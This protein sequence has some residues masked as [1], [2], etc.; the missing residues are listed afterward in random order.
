MKYD[1]FFKRDSR[2]VWVGRYNKN[3]ALKFAGMNPSE[4]ITFMVVGSDAHLS[5][6]SV[7]NS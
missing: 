7:R 6:E 1:A 2:L 3:S 4:S 5:I